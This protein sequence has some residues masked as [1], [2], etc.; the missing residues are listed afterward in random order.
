[1]RYPVSVRC[2]GEFV[3]AMR[4]LNTYSKLLWFGLLFVAGQVRLFAT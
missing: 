2:V 3:S 1:M 4:Y